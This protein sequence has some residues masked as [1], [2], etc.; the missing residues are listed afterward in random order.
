VFPSLHTPFLSHWNSLALEKK[1]QPAL[2]FD[3]PND[4]DEVAL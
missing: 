4:E 2:A 1:N 3:T